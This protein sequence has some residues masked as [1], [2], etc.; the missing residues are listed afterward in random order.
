MPTSEDQQGT[1]AVLEPRSSSVAGEA[2]SRADR[3]LT[4]LCLL[5]LVFGGLATT[6][7]VFGSGAVLS[8][9]LPADGAE[10]QP[11]QHPPQASEPDE[12]SGHMSEPTATEEHAGGHTPMQEPTA[13]EEHAGGHMDGT[14][15]DHEE[16]A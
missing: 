3:A 2:L 1:R 15:S 14:G 11:D 16:D 6:A 4:W 7:V 8:Q 10:V 9:A 13:T 12:H 5:A